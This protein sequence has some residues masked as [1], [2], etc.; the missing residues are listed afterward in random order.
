[1]REGLKHCATAFWLILLLGLCCSRFVRDEKHIGLGLTTT[2]TE[3]DESTAIENDDVTASTR[4]VGTP[5][6][7]QAYKARRDELLTDR[8]HLFNILKSAGVDS[9]TNDD[10]EVLPTWTQVSSLYGSEP[11]IY[12]LETC[13][14]YRTTLQQ[15]IKN[16]NTTDYQ[17]APRV[18]G[19]FNTGT[20]AVSQ[21]MSMNFIM[22]DDYMVYNLFWGKHVP[23]RDIW[24]RPY[25]KDRIETT[26]PIVLV[27]DPMY[28]MQSMCKAPY[29]A[30]WDKGTNRRCPNLIPTSKEQ[31]QLA[32]FNTSSY[33]NNSSFHTFPVDVVVRGKY[34]DHYES[35]AG[36]WSEWNRLW[37]EY[38]LPRLVCLH[39]A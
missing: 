5:S 17:P 25:P 39:Y 8:E 10:I 33:S 14:T 28:W 27:R 21:S 29:N 26:L 38:K 37:L 12:G 9:L 35:L 7:A 20:N 18:A 4:R 11:V 30:K 23:P 19:L 36:L 16:S 22:M 3:E 13:E 32:K 34:R 15:Y 1:M 6:R 2:T 31:H 24:T